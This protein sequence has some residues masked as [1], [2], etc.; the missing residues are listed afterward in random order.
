M[1]DGTADG[2]RTSDVEDPKQATMG[3]GGG[4]TSN[5]RRDV[6]DLPEVFG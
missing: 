2:S 1:I 6:G 5:R 3:A 4:N